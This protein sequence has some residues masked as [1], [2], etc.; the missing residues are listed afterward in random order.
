MRGMVNAHYLQKDAARPFHRAGV[1]YLPAKTSNVYGFELSG[2]YEMPCTPDQ[3][4]KSAHGTGGAAILTEESIG[5]CRMSV[6][7]EAD[8]GWAEAQNHVGSTQPKTVNPLRE[9][10]LNFVLVCHTEIGLLCP[11][12]EEAG[13]REKQLQEGNISID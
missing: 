7:P 11:T 6:A 2:E 3:F 1:D 4:S 9:S 5:I 10:M 13:L 8:V 12:V